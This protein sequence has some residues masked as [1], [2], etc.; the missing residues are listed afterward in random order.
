MSHPKCKPSLFREAQHLNLLSDMQNLSLF[1]KANNLNVSSEKAEPSL[2][3]KAEHL[4]VSSEKQDPQLFRKAKHKILSKNMQK[5]GHEQVFVLNNNWHF[6]SQSQLACV[7]FEQPQM[8]TGLIHSSD[9]LEEWGALK[10]I[11]AGHTPYFDQMGTRH[12]LVAVLFRAH[13]VQMPFDSFTALNH[14]IIG[15][16]TCVQMV[17]IRCDTR[18]H[19]PCNTVDPLVFNCLK[20]MQQYIK[21]SKGFYNMSSRLLNCLETM[22]TR[23]NRIFIVSVLIQAFLAFLHLQGSARVKRCRNVT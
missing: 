2:L 22:K 3:R 6:W 21:C 20:S 4:D 12:C 5:P 15:H 18:M 9:A 7:R 11:F 14:F 19:E 10:K 13:L 16:S 17:L 23:Q 8:F 1:G